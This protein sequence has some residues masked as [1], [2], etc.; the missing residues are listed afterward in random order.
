LV[1]LLRRNGQYLK[2]WTAV[3]V[4]RLV[5]YSREW[6][7][8]E[9]LKLYRAFSVLLQR[10]RA[11]VIEKVLELSPKRALVFTYPCGWHGDVLFL[12]P[13]VTAVGP[14]ETSGAVELVASLSDRVAL[15]V[16]EG[17]WSAEEVFREF[18]PFDVGIACLG[19]PLPDIRRYVHKMIVVKVGGPLGGLLEVVYQPHY[20]EANVD[21]EV[22]V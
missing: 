14:F 12:A 18:G 5:I 13:Y 21:M 3:V 9:V 8:E 16:L 10:H 22:P 2:G 20:V 7:D 1:L 11:Y 15:V 17:S 19:S 6:R 4:K